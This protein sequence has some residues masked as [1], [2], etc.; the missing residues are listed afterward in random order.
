MKIKPQSIYKEN[1]C[2]THAYE[3][4]GHLDNEHWVYSE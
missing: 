2:V 3:H 4:C 1:T